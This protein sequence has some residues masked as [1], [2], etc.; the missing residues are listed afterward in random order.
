MDSKQL[1][2]YA[3]QRLGIA[4]LNAMQQ[5]SID[6]CR[7]ARDVV[8]LAPTGSGKT[9]AYLIPLFTRTQPQ[10]S[11]TQ[12]VIIVPTR[13]LAQQVEQVARTIA[14]GYR[15]VCCYG[16]H[17]FRDEARSLETSADIVLGTPGRL[18]DHVQR[19]RL[20][21]EQVDTLVLDEFDKSLELGFHNE[22]RT[23]IR[24]MKKLQ[25]RILTSATDLPE[26]PDFV[27]M[28]NATK[29]YYI[30]NT[31][32][33]EQKQQLAVYHVASPEK[34]KLNT[35]YELLCRIDD[36][37]TIIFCNQ[38][39]SVERV[40]D[41]LKKK[42]VVCAAFHG[43]ME[44][45]DRERALCRF[46][47]RSTNICVATD[48][49]ARGLDI[50]A[51]GHVIHYHLPLD[52]E[53]YTHR[54]GRTARMDATGNA[55]LIVAPQEELPLYID[56]IRYLRLDS[57]PH[58]PATPAMETLHFA[59]GK[60]EKLSKGDILGFLTRMC[61]LQAAEV[62]LIEVKD[63]YSY[64]AIARNRIHEVLEKAKTEKIKGRRIKVNRAF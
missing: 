37:P 18:L 29:L 53:A 33:T 8:L 31:R 49:A 12:A 56:D 36:S 63:H 17:S 5:A 42:R 59:A 7:D 61:E 4:S 23:L 35:L 9:L 39:E 55:Y 26:I 2:A 6:T 28:N 11:R 15:I 21:L 1:I 34:D 19:G 27:A 30:D 16:G 13:E 46:R 45:P 47:N 41:F 44:Q 60:R 48:L 62:G 32:K 51:V 22:M 50:A 52:A 14:S 25:M 54:N 43:G 38:R 20:S 24:N 40:A 64:A 58:A 10:A 3:C 57:E